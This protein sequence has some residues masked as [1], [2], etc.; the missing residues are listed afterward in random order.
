MLTIIFNNKLITMR[1]DQKHFPKLLFTILCLIILTSYWKVQQDDAYIFYSYASN[2]EGGNGYVFN[3]GEKINATTSPLYTLLVSFTYHN[4]KWMSNVT[5]PLVAHLIGFVCLWLLC[6]FGYKIF[7][8]LNFKNGALLFPIIFLANPLLRNAVGMEIFLT[9]MLIMASLFAYLKNKMYLFWLVG[10]LAVLARFDSI[11]FI[12]IVFIYDLITTKKINYKPIIIFVV[13][14]LPWFIYSYFYFGELLPR[15]IYAKIQQGASGYWGDGSLFFSHFFSSFPGGAALGLIITILGLAGFVIASIIDKKY[16][17]NK[18][19]LIII[20]W[21]VLLFLI[22][23]L[24]LNPPGY[25]W[26][27]TF[28]SI[29]ITW[30]FVLAFEAV[31]IKLNIQKT[32]V[33]AAYLVIFILAMVLPYK[34]FFKP[35][36]SKYILYKSASEWLNLNAEFGSNV[37]ADEVGILRFF[38]QKGKVHD[39]LGLTSNYSNNEAKEQK[40]AYMLVD[41]PNPPEYLKFTKE[42]DFKNYYASRTI[43]R[44]GN[45]KLIIYEKIK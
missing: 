14:L 32:L 25:Q 3:N 40:P 7:E 13:L 21:Q 41:Y 23:G 24:I 17:L 2:I 28:Y 30:G 31:V 4:V 6:Y 22:Y 42:G 20:I 26:Y 33:Y 43:I 8:H 5:V 37:A 19:T 12:L 27:Y 16:I 35:Y 38:Y 18:A 34:T 45:Q 36:S 1:I 11:L 44:G 39:V 9:L 29:I 10:A 15:S